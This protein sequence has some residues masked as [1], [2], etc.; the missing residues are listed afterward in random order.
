MNGE[1]C[2]SFRISPNFNQP[3]NSMFLLAPK[4]TNLSRIIKLIKI[5]Q[6]KRDFP[7]HRVA[8]WPHR[9]LQCR[10]CIADL[11]PCRPSPPRKVCN[12]ADLPPGRSATL[13]TFPRKICNI[14]D[15]P[16]RGKVCNIADSPLS[17]QIFPGGR[18]ATLQTFPH[19][20][21][22]PESHFRMY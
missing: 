8:D 1:M 20:C 19:F 5:T 11:P 4:L 15:L 9:S 7:T 18:S 12:I 13:Q 10:C 3:G 2:V 22:V 21:K 6:S 17:L 14:A 16:P